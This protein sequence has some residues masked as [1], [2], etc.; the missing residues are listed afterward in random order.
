MPMGPL[1]LLDE[2]GFDVAAHAGVS[3][4]A[5]YGARMQSSHLIRRA[6]EVGIKGKKTGKGFYLHGVDARTGRPKRGG[7][8]PEVKRF[9]EP[10]A[11]KMDHSD[12]A[13]LDQ[14]LLSMLNEA[15]RCLEE[16][17]VASAR[18][19]DLASVF[20]MGFAPFRGGLLRWGDSVGPLDVVARLRR[21]ADA[22]DVLA[23]VEGAARFQPAQ[24]LT[25]LG[26][27]GGRFHA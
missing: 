26:Q 23:R 25:A 11:R 22:P 3:L 19:L 15:A 18:E 9:I 1:E 6:L 7:P 8:N 10:S 24:L 27:H 14:L 2:V 4:G 16:G 12:A 20:G 5:A 21:I 13:I 17:V